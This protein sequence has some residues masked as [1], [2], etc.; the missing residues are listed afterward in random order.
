MSVELGR[1]V[2]DAVGQELSHDKT[3]VDVARE[4]TSKSNWTNLGRVCRSDDCICAEDEASKDLAGNKCGKRSCEEL[5]EYEGCGEYDAC[6]K[7]FLPAE[8]LHANILF[9]K[10]LLSGTVET[11]G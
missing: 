7:R 4:Y 9:S 3:E 5:D 1:A 6:S 11:Y 8:P 10:N 2:S